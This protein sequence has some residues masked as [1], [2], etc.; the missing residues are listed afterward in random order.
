MDRNMRSQ[1]ETEMEHGVS[2][3][4]SK[5]EGISPSADD[6]KDHEGGIKIPPDQQSPR[7]ASLSSFGWVV[8]CSS[9]LLAELQAAL[10][11]TITADLQP[12]IIGTFGEISKFPWIN[13]TYSLGMGGSCLLWGKL[14]ACFDSKHILLV[15]RVLFAIG[16]A[17]TAAAPSMNAFIVGKVVTGVGS[18]G[19]YISIIYIITT[20]TTASEQGRYFGY[21]GFM[22]GLGTILGPS[23]GGAFAVTAAGWRWS[24]YFN[25]ILVG[26]TFPVF[27]FILPSRKKPDFSTSLWARARRIDI[28]GS[29]VFAGAL[30]SGIMAVSFAGALYSWNSGAVIGLFCCS[31]ILWIIFGI[32]QATATFTTEE[33][34]ILPIHVLRSWEMW[35][36]IVQTGCSISILFITIYYIPLYFQFVR[37]ESAIQSAVDLLPFLFTSVSAMLISGRLITS[38]AYYKLWFIAGSSLA[39]IMSVC[40]YT[41]EIDTSHGKIYGYLI[42]GGVGTGMYA[43][44]AGPVMSGIVAK[45][46]IADAS[47][48]FGCVDTLCGAF[49]VGVA[50]SIFVNRASD[51]IQKLLPDTPRATVQ[52]AIAGVGASLTQQLP[53][54]LRAAILQA[55]L[56]A[57]KDVWIQM[58]ATAALSFVLSLF[59]RNR[60]LSDLR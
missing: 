14:L 18:S 13:V 42:L 3:H 6:E 30:C 34:R 16:S 26:V 51:S 32:Q 28:V 21:I 58:I 17:L 11:S 35:I 22:W 40:L 4:P 36:L 1:V 8:L 53:A 59:L 54:P 7:S 27:V 10:D 55:G 48:V 41:T 24:F 31:G 39:L 19:S 20:L 12:T 15:A 57:I 5:E 45:E 37:G 23:I 46:H 33:D 9:M 25:L 43:M 52:E 44:N 29:V 49:S 60:K 50:N 2:H 38:F 56:D 47:T